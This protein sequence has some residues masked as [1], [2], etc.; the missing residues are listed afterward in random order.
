ML[1]FASS[2]ATARCL[3]AGRSA[4]ADHDG[5]TSVSK[6]S[7][8]VLSL[9]L[10]A[11]A[12]LSSGCLQP[13]KEPL[14]NR[15]T[16]VRLQYRVAADWFE[17]RT[18]KD[19]TRELAMSL[20]ARNTGKECLKQVT[21]LLRVVAGD[22]TDRVRQ[23]LTLDVSH[24]PPMGSG[25]LEPVVRSVEVYVNEK[26]ILQMEDVPDK[27]ERRLY[28]EYGQDVSSPAPAK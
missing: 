16:R 2:G 14:I 19:G 8:V 24:I 27:Q 18:A 15:V 12:G 4:V 23:P 1:D 3:G 7:A 11:A 22:G 6:K 21:L 10:V 28:P 5:R 26:L 25:K 13:S 17:M 20:V 9:S